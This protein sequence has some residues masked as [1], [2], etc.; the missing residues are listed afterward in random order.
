MKR[1]IFRRLL[2]PKCRARNASEQYANFTGRTIKLV[3]S[4][5]VRCFD[6]IDAVLVYFILQYIAGV[7]RA[8]PITTIRRLPRVSLH[9]FAVVR[10]ISSPANALFVRQLQL[11]ISHKKKKTVRFVN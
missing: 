10:E 11:F 9:A 3:F 6:Q 1:V 2:L 4:F 8:R 7:I 5:K